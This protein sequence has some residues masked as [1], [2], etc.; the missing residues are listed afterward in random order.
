MRPPAH[1]LAGPKA[2]KGGGDSDLLIPFFFFSSHSVQNKNPYDRLH[3]RI[4]SQMSS[5]IPKRV[6][7]FFIHSN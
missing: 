6:P 2:G 7:Y 5:D 3:L 4:S 1:I